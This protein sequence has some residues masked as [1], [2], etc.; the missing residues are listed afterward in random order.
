MGSI[1]NEIQ[2]Y[3]WFMMVRWV[4]SHE[5]WDAIIYTRPKNISFTEIKNAPSHVITLWVGS[6]T[7]RLIFKQVRDKEI[8]RLEHARCE[9]FY[10]SS[11]I[12][13]VN[14][15][16][17]CIT[18]RWPLWESLSSLFI[19]ILSCHITIH[20][21]PLHLCQYQTS[22]GERGQWLLAGGL[23]LISR[24][25]EEVTFYC[26]EYKGVLYAW[27]FQN[28]KNVNIYW[29][30]YIC[31]VLSKRLYRY[32]ARGKYASFSNIA[33][34]WV[35]GIF[36]VCFVLI[37]FIFSAALNGFFLTCF[38]CFTIRIKLSW[39][40]I[41]ALGMLLTS[42]WNASCESMTLGRTDVSLQYICTRLGFELW[43]NNNVGHVKS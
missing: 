9:V 2:S 17:M 29:E 3:N 39:G 14:G 19:L 6:K 21:A 24:C 27:R 10:Q 8:S 4:H 13:R 5:I 28:K 22:V 32:E 18:L 37:C 30:I 31:W 35:W 34:K 23:Q 7:S 11:N 38:D 25:H 33:E 1:T 12:Q 15:K 42:I 20:M 26:R 43:I 36:W 40:Q 16:M 41:Y